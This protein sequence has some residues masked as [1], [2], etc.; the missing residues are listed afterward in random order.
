MVT[1][2]PIVLI[3]WIDACGGGDQWISLEDLLRQELVTHYSI[4]YLVKEDTTST[5][6]TMSYENDEESMGAFLV[7]PNVNIINKTTL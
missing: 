1:K 2:Y 7:I 6:I 4:G 3:T 5:I